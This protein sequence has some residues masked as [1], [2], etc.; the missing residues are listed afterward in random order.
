MLKNKS[1]LSF[2]RTCH[3][4]IHFLHCFEFK[5]LKRQSNWNQN[6]NLCWFWWNFRFDSQQSLVEDDLDDRPLTLE[7]SRFY[8]SPTSSNDLT[9]KDN[10]DDSISVDKTSNTSVD[11]K[12]QLS[13]KNSFDT[14]SVSTVSTIDYQSRV[15]TVAEI[16]RHVD[17]VDNKH[18][19]ENLRQ[20]ANNNIRKTDVDENYN[21]RRRYDVEET[22]SEMSEDGTTETLSEDDDHQ[23]SV[24]SMASSL[25]R[26]Q[27]HHHHFTSG[28]F[29]WKCFAQLFCAY[30]LG[31]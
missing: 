22:S 7:F 24:N 12:R 8:V 14:E 23:R 1:F 31:L 10:K 21:E 25:N 18:L 26:C 13:A 6:L 4:C 16:H 11:T 9:S 17:N 30:S 29:V 28:F 15:I 27:F 3:F 20:N 19:D 5:N 2:I